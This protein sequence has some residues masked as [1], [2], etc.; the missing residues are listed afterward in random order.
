MWPPAAACISLP[1]P[2]RLAPGRGPRPPL[3]R[4]RPRHPHRSP[5]GHQDRR[6]RPPALTPR[7]RRAGRPS[8]RQSRRHRLSA[9]PGR[10]GHVGLAPLPRPRCEGGGALARRHGS[11]AAPFLRQH[12]GRWRGLRVDHRGVRRAPLRQ[13]D[14]PLC[15]CT[16]TPCFSRP[17]TASRRR[18][19]RPWARRRPWGRLFQSRGCPDGRTWTFIPPPAPRHCILCSTT[20]KLS[21]TSRRDPRGGPLRLGASGRRLVRKPSTTSRQ[22]WQALID[23]RAGPRPIL[24]GARARATKQLD[25]RSS[26]HRVPLWKSIQPR[27]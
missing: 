18:S 12:G 22:T 3:A 10:D 15:P 27:A 16:P 24:P 4:R 26:G 5:S 9:E 17:Q 14:E 19:R 11:C 20:A 21:R 23:E 13:R 6:E 8:P 2:H 1:R 25:R 7:L